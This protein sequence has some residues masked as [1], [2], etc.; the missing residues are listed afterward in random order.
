MGH[1]PGSG[2][3]PYTVLSE[4]DLDHHLGR[5]SEHCIVEGA[6]CVSLQ[7]VPMLDA[8]QD[9]YVVQK[10]QLPGSAGPWRLF[11]IFDGHAGHDTV[12]HTER[13]LPP[14]L[15]S[16]LEAA[17]SAAAGAALPP[18]AVA[19]VLRSGIS[20][21]DD[22]LTRSLTDLFPGGPQAIA[23]LSDEDIRAATTD[24]DGNP[25]DV[26]R[27]CMTG[28]TALVALVDPARNLYVASVGDCQ[29]VL[30]L[31]DSAGTWDASILSANHHGMDE[32][33][34][35]RVRSEHPGEDECILND[36]VLGRCAITRAV[37]DQ[38][39]K[40]PAIYGDRVFRTAMPGG[41]IVRTLHETLPRNLTP[42]YLSN[43]ADVRHVDLSAT[44]AQKTVLVMASD[45]LVNQ[46]SGEILSRDAA[47]EWIE[48]AGG[49]GEKPALALLRRALGGDDVEKVSAMLTVEMEERWM[50]DTTIVVAQL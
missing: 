45:G 17:L 25:V 31:Q 8:N 28:T 40:L 35:A 46:F 2:P 23:R 50:D 42:P 14:L 15:Q 26:I 3:W 30:G 10:W 24:E 12:D 16:R 11:A 38:L 7:P 9:R 20:E 5:L 43:A 21:F 39:Y 18:A 34:A 33:E 47:R 36:R 48:V 4:A 27:R 29:A 44:G 49:A 6:D 1:M 37:G 19:D 32:A 13:E 22:G 41:H